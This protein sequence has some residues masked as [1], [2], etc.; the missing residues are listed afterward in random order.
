MAVEPKRVKLDHT[1]FV[2]LGKVSYSAVQ[3]GVVELCLK[4]FATICEVDKIP[5]QLK[6]AGRAILSELGTKIDLPLIDGTTFTWT[7]ARPQAVLVKFVG[8][9]PA[10]QRVV[11][12]IIATKTWANPLRDYTLS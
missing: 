6:V 2:G 9:S 3:S 4:I 7:V 5:R 1:Y 12:P 10:L 8:I 11:R